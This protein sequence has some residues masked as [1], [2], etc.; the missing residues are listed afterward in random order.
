M[1]TATTDLNETR[2]K[3]KSMKHTTLIKL[4]F[5]LERDII[6]TSDCGPM[7][8]ATVSI[9]LSDRVCTKS[10]SNSISKSISKSKSTSK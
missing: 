8:E 2:L 5:K 10:I 9:R 7:N 3:G 4:S 1:V 6:H